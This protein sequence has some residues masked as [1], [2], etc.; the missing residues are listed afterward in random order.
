METKSEKALTSDEIDEIYG[1]KA[2]NFIVI[3][4]QKKL[5]KVLHID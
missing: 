5:R 4:L 1:E 2:L 3:M